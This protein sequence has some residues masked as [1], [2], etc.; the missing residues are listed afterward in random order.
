[1]CRG[2]VF[3]IWEEYFLQWIALLFTCSL[4][5]KYV[6]STTGA[7]PLLDNAAASYAFFVALLVAFLAL[8]K[9]KLARRNTSELPSNIKPENPTNFKHHHYLHFSD[10]EYPYGHLEEG[11]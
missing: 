11:A 1:V 4:T 10:I 7:N 6:N 9:I 5:F 8:H 2:P 3:S